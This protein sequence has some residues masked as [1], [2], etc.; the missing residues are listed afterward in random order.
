ML[1]REEIAEVNSIFEISM[2][3]LTAAGK[4]VKKYIT[5]LNYKEQLIISEYN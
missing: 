5:E 2:A 3:K 1:P 4:Q